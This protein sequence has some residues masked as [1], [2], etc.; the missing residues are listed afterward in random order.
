M[1]VLSSLWADRIFQLS[2]ARPSGHLIAS[3][4]LQQGLPAAIFLIILRGIIVKVWHTDLY[5]EVATMIEI[6]NLTKIYPATGSSPMV[7]ALDQV[8]LTIDTGDIFGIIGLSGAGKSTLIRCINLLERPTEGEILV[9]GLDV[10]KLNAHDLRAFRSRFGMVFQDYNL[11]MQRTVAR[12]IA[13]PLEISG[14]PA[15]DRAAR[16]TEL[17]ELVGL[18]DKANAYPAQLSGGQKQ[19]VSIARALATHP[20]FLLCDE[21]TSALDSLT[22]TSI[23]NLLSDINRKL[24]VS[25]IIITHETSVVRRICRHMAVLSENRILETGAVTDLVANPQSALTRQL[26]KLEQTV[27]EDAAD[28]FDALDAFEAEVH[29]HE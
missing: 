29:A 6:R 24:G 28:A 20:E 2:A 10:A 4:R 21:P 25:I 3:T 17:L 7:R 19:R 14:I 27:A 9:D 5:H 15:P 1:Q 8:N 16:V 18:S 22:T 26:L 12:N 11:F 13:F 23:L